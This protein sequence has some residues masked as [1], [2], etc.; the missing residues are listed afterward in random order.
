MGI[1]E[2]VVNNVTNELN[3]IN[4]TGDGDFIYLIL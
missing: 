4:I 3:D 1:K 2:T